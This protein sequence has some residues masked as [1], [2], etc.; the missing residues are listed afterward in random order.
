MCDS[1]S[2]QRELVSILNTLKVAS[3]VARLT[4]AT[5]AIGGYSIALDTQLAMYTG[6][7]L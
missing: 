5:T 4:V 2:L 7:L 1:K 3:Y 6:Y